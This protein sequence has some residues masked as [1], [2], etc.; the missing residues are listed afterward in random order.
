MWKH[1]TVS[2]A[3]RHEIEIVTRMAN[4]YFCR[5]QGVLVSEYCKKESTWIGFRDEVPYAIGSEFKA[6]L[7][8][9]Q[10]EK[11]KVASAKKEQKEISDLEAVSLVIG[12]GAQYWLNLLH[13]GSNHNLISQAE[14][15]HLFLAASMAEKGIIPSTSS[16]SVP[17]G[18][19][20]TVQTVR[21]VE[22]RLIAEGIQ[23][24]TGAIKLTLTDYVLH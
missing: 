16:G 24:E 12:A 13:A 19:M 14:K 1:Q 9:L 4:D 10:M 8:P 7:V 23:P 5:N 20:L 22:E 6:E 15:H 2:M 18:V 21:A 11:E 17:K 3:L